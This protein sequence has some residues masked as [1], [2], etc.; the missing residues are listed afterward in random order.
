M[1]STVGGYIAFFFVL[2]A[3]CCV[4]L[5]VVDGC[6]THGRDRGLDKST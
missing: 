3:V 4:L 5:V 2:C 6:K 1:F